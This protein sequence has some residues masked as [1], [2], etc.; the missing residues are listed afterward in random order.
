MVNKK[1][2]SFRIVPYFQEAILQII[3]DIF[4]IVT[5]SIIFTLLKFPIIS[6]IFISVSYFAIVLFFHYRVIILALIDKRKGDYI[7]ETVSIKKFV[8]EFSFAGDRLGNS[9]I[10]FFYPKEMQV[11]KYKLNTI[12][13]YN[14]KKNLRSV[15]SFRRL[16]QF[17]VL[18][19]QQIEYIQVTYLKR[20]KILIQV[21]LIEELDKNISRKKQEQINKSIH[22][23][24][25]SI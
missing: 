8:D 6:L 14:E 23:I 24:N 7:T 9:K 3:L 13:N 15:M 25:K 2:V 22:F 21:D 19:K 20:S 5:I 4:I 16:V 10:R 1:K 18:D 17:M 12:S 11:R